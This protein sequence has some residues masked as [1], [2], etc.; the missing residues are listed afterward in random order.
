M[1]TRHLRIW[2]EA[3]EPRTNPQDGVPHC[4]DSCRHHDGKRCELLG[5]RAGGLCEPE[6][7]EMAAEL[8]E[9]RKA[10]EARHA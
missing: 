1:T 9:F 4:D 5:F 8:K 6:V 3:P 2:K 10:S 7:A